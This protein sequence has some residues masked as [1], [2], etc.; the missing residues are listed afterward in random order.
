MVD[1][2]RLLALDADFAFAVL[3]ILVVQSVESCFV[4][5]V[6]SAPVG[7]VRL[8]S[9]VLADAG[10]GDITEVEAI[11]VDDVCPAALWKRSGG[12]V[13][14]GGFEAVLQALSELGVDWAAPGG[15]C[16][17]DGDV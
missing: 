11:G 4:A 15:A 6:K 14:V 7:S 16:A 17:A 12:A 2:L 13:F 1:L 10:D 9:V 3:A 5:V 8:L